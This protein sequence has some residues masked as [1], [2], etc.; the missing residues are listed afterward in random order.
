[1]ANHLRPD[2]IS[3]PT[4]CDSAIGPMK[5]I[6]LQFMPFNAR[7]KNRTKLDP[8]RVKTGRAMMMNIKE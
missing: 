8:M 7:N 6:A 1:L 5:L 2:E 3:N 4:G